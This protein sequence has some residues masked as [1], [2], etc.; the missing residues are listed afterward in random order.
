MLLRGV[1]DCLIETPAGLT[2]LDYKTDRRK[3]A[4]DWNARIRGYSTQMQLYAAAAS[5]IFG[6]PVIRLVLVCLRER[7]LV[8][9]K[10]TCP[11]LNELFGTA[12][13]A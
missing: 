12:Q 2:L 8:E 10:V 6:R 7:Q 11:N 1:I 4:E 5:E 13:L 9:P 3:S